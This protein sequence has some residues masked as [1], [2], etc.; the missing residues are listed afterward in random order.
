MLCA[1]PCTG[2]ALAGPR[3]MLNKWAAP[4][5]APPVPGWPSVRG[6]VIAPGKPAGT[7]GAGLRSMAIWASYWDLADCPVTCMGETAAGPWLW[8]ILSASSRCLARSACSCP[9][10]CRCSLLAAALANAARRASDIPVPGL[11]HACY[12]P[13]YDAWV[14]AGLSFQSGAAS[15]L[16]ALVSGSASRWVPPHPVAVSSCSAPRALLPG[17]SG[18]A[19]APRTCSLEC[20][21]SPS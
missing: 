8:R 10:P 12:A 7:R 2:E 18:D 20:I 13:C 9:W 11:D 16:K 1:W 4:R 15:P 21:L 5:L 6:G 3:S 14:P 17:M 19:G